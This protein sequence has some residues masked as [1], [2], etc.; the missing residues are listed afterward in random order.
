MS[1]QGFESLSL[2]SR[3]QVP[4][5]ANFCQQVLSYGL[6]WAWVDTCS[7]D[8]TSSAELSEAINS[9]FRWYRNADACYVYLSDIIWGDR[10][11]VQSPSSAKFGS[12][13]WFERGW[14]LQELLAPK[15]VWFF[16]QD[17][18]YFGSRDSLAAEITSATGITQQYLSNPR[19]AS[20]AIKMSWAAKRQTSRLEDSAYCLLGLFD[21]SMPMLY[22]EGE[23]AFL[24]LQLEIIR[25]SDDESIFAWVDESQKLPHGMLA[26]W[27]TAYARSGNIIRTSIRSIE[28]A[29]YAMTNK[30]LE[31]RL[32]LPPNDG[33]RD[34]DRHRTLS[35]GLKC[36][37][38]SSEG[39]Q[40]QTLAIELHK[41]ETLDHWQRV[42]CDTPL[43]EKDVVETTLRSGA[44]FGGPQGLLEVAECTIYVKAAE[45]T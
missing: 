10:D 26:P 3:E 18:R 28:R 17:W 11:H 39:D 5:I 19:S 16:D 23:K 45:S 43:I 38:A 35:F 2:K 15:A 37:R 34:Q 13:K 6:Q 42:N 1:L 41:H 9:M 25:S 14:T 22:G 29:P 7:I 21:I 40:R 20:A 36:E 12:S 8:K 31:L 24:R 27:P 44:N 33:A 4:K 32:R 30:D